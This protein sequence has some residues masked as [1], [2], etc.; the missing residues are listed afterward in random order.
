M[1]LQFNGGEDWVAIPRDPILNLNHSDFTIEMWFSMIEKPT[2]S[3]VLLR[4]GSQVNTNLELSLDANWGLMASVW[5]STGVQDT[6]RLGSMDGFNVDQWYHTALTWDGDYLCLLL[7]NEVQDSIALGGALHFRTSDSLA[8]GGSAR[9]GS[10]FNGMIDEIRFSNMQRQVW[11]INVQP[12]KIEVVP[13]QLDFGKVLLGQSRT[14]QFV[15]SNRGDQDLNIYEISGAGGVYT[16]TDSLS[17]LVVTAWNQQNVR[18]TYTPD[19]DTTQNSHTTVL[20]ISSNDASNDAVEVTLTGNSTDSKDIDP[21]T[22]DPHTVALYHFD[23]SSE[24]SVIDSSGGNHHGELK[25]GVARES[26]FFGNALYFDGVDDYV[27]IPFSDDLVFD[28]AD[29]SFTIECFFRTDTLSQGLIFMGPSDSAN[30]GLSF[31]MHGHLEAVG[32]GTV[33]RQVS[34]NSWHHVAQTYNHLDQM[35]KLYIDGLIQW[36]GQR[37]DTGWNGAVSSLIIGASGSLSGYFEGYIDEVRI[38]DIA[39]EPWE[40]QLVSYGIED[41]L[42][43]TPFTGSS[44]NIQVKVPTNLSA[45]DDG[46]SVYYRNGGTTSY[47]SVV[48]TKEDSSTYVATIPSASINLYGLE[49]YIRVKNISGSDTLTLTNPVLDPENNPKTASVHHG[50][51]VSPN[52]LPYRQYQ[53]ISV[54]FN[55]EYGSIDSVFSDGFDPYDPYQSRFFWWE[56]ADS[57]YMEFPDSLYNFDFNPGQAYWIISSLERAY[58]VGSG[59]TVTTDSS[60]QISL[61]P[62]WNMI[63]TPYNFTIRWD[64]CSLTSDSVLTLYSWDQQE[65][66]AFDLPYMEPWEGYWLYNADS[67]RSYLYVLPKQADIGKASQISRGLLTDIQENEWFFKLSAESNDIKD[68]CNFAGIRYNAKREWDILDRPEPPHI[69]SAISL[70]FD[71]SQWKD[72]AGIYA[73]DIRAPGRDGYIWEFVIETDFS[74]KSVRLYWDLIGD[75]PGKWG[76]FLFDMNEG[77]STNMIQMQARTYKTNKQNPNYRHFKMVVGTPEFIKDNNDGISLVPL[78]FHLYHNYPNPFN[79]AT[80]IK[81]SLPKNGDVNLMIFNTI[82]QR[83]RVLVDEVQKSGYHEVVWNGRDGHGKLVSSGIYIYR[84]EASSEV[85]TRKMMILR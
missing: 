54:P 22:A 18:V 8:I 32:F 69:S 28:P 36:S 51:I 12:R 70:Y 52:E 55:L 6:L 7:N 79:P 77:T 64:D 4:R 26:G 76:A 9:A 1:A 72:H 74:E 58:D 48:A 46:V 42:L 25:N 10:H 20:V 37:S 57:V 16:L 60:F 67:V 29:E 23:E 39:R 82:G 49:Y 81:Y 35:G 85:A 84:L 62:G 19:A 83:V 50:E 3:Y 45:P 5:D 63:G 68:R 71:N 78:K 80:T 34:D 75:L 38:S 40:F 73:A 14:L 27:E 66:P 13:Y 11:E 24:I 43:N 59:W 15:V 65:D 21:Y 61:N 53:M 2:G 47:A 30:Y 17:D 44:L 33:E 41:S 31:N 56:P